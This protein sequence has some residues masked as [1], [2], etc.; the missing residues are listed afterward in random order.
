MISVKEEN[1]KM[2]LSKD[3]TFI[4]K[5]LFAIAYFWCYIDDLNGCIKKFLF[6]LSIEVKGKNVKCRQKISKYDVLFYSL[7]W[8]KDMASFSCKYYKH[9]LKS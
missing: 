1:T 2:T 4:E 7:S 5:I 9:F 8:Q 3:Y 6:E